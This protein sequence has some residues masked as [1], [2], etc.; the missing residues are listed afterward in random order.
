M[1]GD[2]A[3]LAGDTA[4]FN[5]LAGPTE[6]GF[7][8]AARPVF[9]SDPAAV[10]DAIERREYRGIVHFA[11]VRF[12]PRRHCRDLHMPDHGHVLFEA[13]DQI[14]ADDLGMIEVELD[15]HVRPLHLGDDIGRVLGAGEKIVGPVA[16]ID[17][18]DQHGHV[19]LARRIGR[20]GEIADKSRLRRWTLLRRHPAGE[21]VD[22]APPDRG[23]VVERLLEHGG[24]FLL[25]AGNR[26]HA[27]LPRRRSA[28]RGIDTEHGQAVTFELGLDGGGR[29]IIGQ[30]QLDRAEAGRGRRCKTFYQRAFGEKIG[31]VG[32]EAR[33]RQRLRLLLGHDP[34]PLD[35]W[36]PLVDLPAHELAERRGRLSGF[37]R[38]LDRKLQ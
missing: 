7:G 8:R 5:D 19:L 2:G 24:E 38:E 32:G 23:D 35:D 36:H 11:F 17:R 37:G 3:R 25:A 26:R 10:T 9:A 31:Q 22:L 4:Q 1:T 34:G 33:H 20:P 12:V 6:P 16:R 29:V 30:L 28:G 13:L 18:L 27:E 21:A 14:A 15:A